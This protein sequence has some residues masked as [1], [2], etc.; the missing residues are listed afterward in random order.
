MQIIR[1]KTHHV[2]EIRY[3]Q[4]I[5]LR[6]MIRIARTTA[7]EMY[8]SRYKKFFVHDYAKDY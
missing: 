1:L 5:I 3:E 2:R 6:I 7:E 8:I 4:E